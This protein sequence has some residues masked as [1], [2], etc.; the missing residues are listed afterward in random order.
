M[1]DIKGLIKSKNDMISGAPAQQV[2]IDTLE[3]ELQLVFAREYKQYLR[4]F[5]FICLEGHEL[6]GACKVK[7]L[8]VAKVTQTE[9]ANNEL[10][11][12]DL[13]VIEQANIDGIVIWQSKSGIVYQS[14]PN[15]KPVKICN[16]LYE[17]IEQF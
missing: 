5:G 7:R 12:N 9:W 3:E 6:T 13:Y 17:Y 1:K 2:E 15:M 14:Q 8:N 16:S 4:E 11:P 10:V